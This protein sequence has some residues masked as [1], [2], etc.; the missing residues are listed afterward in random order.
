MLVSVIYMKSVL[1]LGTG[2]TFLSFGVSIIVSKH[3]NH[4]SLHYQIKY[5]SH[6][7][8][9]GVKIH[10]YSSSLSVHISWYII[11]VFLQRYCLFD[12]V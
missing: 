1:G 3:S 7:A 4:T 12:G 6:L 2:L 11:Y 10:V 8:D 5:I 9:V